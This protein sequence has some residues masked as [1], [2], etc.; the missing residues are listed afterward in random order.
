MGILH[1]TKSFLILFSPLFV[2]YSTFSRRMNITGL[3]TASSSLQISSR[4]KPLQS[5]Q[6]LSR[7]A[8]RSKSTPILGFPSCAASPVLGHSRLFRTLYGSRSITQLQFR[9]IGGAPLC[10]LLL[11]CLHRYNASHSRS[12]S[13]C[14][15]HKHKS[16]PFTFTK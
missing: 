16:L 1:F 11:C 12:N 3:V 14:L 15:Q 4:D 2:S 10:A 8:L 13:R 9:T 7:Q 6:V 5:G